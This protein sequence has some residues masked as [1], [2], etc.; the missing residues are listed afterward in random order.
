MRSLTVDWS[1]YFGD[2]RGPARTNRQKRLFPLQLSE[3]DRVLVCCLESSQSVIRRSHRV[4]QR[5]FD[6]LGHSAIRSICQVCGGVHSEAGRNVQMG[7]GGGSEEKLACFIVDFHSF[8]V[9]LFGVFSFRQT[10]TFLQ[11]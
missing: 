6:E 11:K 2:S 7:G 3:V 10:Q 8:A 5:C 9:T 1:V 4:E